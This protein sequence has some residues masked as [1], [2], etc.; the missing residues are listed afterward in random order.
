MATLSDT[1]AECEVS[2]LTAPTATDNCEG[3]ING[4]HDATLPITSQGTTI[5]TWTYDDGNSNISSQTQNIVIEDLT[6]PTI[7]CVDNQVVVADDTHT[8]TVSGTEF[9]PVTTDDNCNVA[10]VLN[11]FNNTETLDG[12]S[13]PEGTTTIVWTVSDDAGNQETCSFDVLVNAYTVG[14]N[15]I[16]ENG[17]SIY[18]NPTNGIVTIKIGK[19]ALHTSQIKIIDT[20]GKTIYI[21]LSEADKTY[22]DMSAYGSGIYF[23]E[24]SI[25]DKT[26]YKKVV[27]K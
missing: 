8:Y 16:S 11:D 12:A 20:N 4:T 1:N 10:S 5:V 13:L 18:P 2:S 25:G 22:I 17:I 6:S 27:V 19:D 15:T 23:L 24:L 21:S 3:S 7:T 14:L 9:N 26:F